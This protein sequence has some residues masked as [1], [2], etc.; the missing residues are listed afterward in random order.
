MTINIGIMTLSHHNRR[1]VRSETPLTLSVCDIIGIIRN[2]SVYGESCWDALSVLLP[3]SNGDVDAYYERRIDKVSKMFRRLAEKTI[4]YIDAVEHLQHVQ[5]CYDGR[6]E[7]KNAAL[8]ALDCIFIKSQDSD[9]V[10]IETAEKLLSMPKNMSLNSLR[11]AC[12]KAEIDAAKARVALENEVLSKAKAYGFPVEEIAKRIER[13]GDRCV[14]VAAMML[15]EFADVIANA[16]KV[17]EE[18]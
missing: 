7:D 16:A 9:T 6:R 8:D 12:E 3:Y 17:K 1:R 5:A 15:C 11:M 18:E 10:L 2:P 13:N 4:Y 14:N